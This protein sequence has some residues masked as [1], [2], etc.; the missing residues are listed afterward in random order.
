MSAEATVVA[1][2]RRLARQGRR[3]KKRSKVLKDLKKAE[4]VLEADHYGLEK[5]KE[6]ILEYLAVQQRVKK[7][8]GPDP[9]PR[10][11]AGRPARPRWA[12]ASRARRTASSCVCP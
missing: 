6:R 11:S 8:K 2:L 1:Q 12:R 3:G 9:V 5:V 10:R 7:L 4:E